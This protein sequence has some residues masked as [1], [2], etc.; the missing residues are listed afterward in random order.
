M[1]T[2]DMSMTRKI[3]RRMCILAGMAV[4]SVAAHAFTFDVKIAIDRAL[5]SPTLTVRYSGANVALV[6]LKV[7]GESVGTRS[8]T[9]S[10]ANGETN[11]TIDLSSLHDG[12][13]SV[14]ISLFDKNGKLVGS[15]KSNISTDD[16]ANSPVFLSAPKVGAT[17]Q[18]PVEIK[19]GFGR[20]LRNSYVSFFIDNQF[21]AMMNVAPFSYIWDSAKEANGWHELEAWVVDDSSKT[22]KTRKVKIFVNNPGGQ[23]KRPVESTPASNPTNPT[24]GSNSGIKPTKGPSADPVKT[25]SVTTPG[26]N[27]I[28][29]LNPDLNSTGAMSGTKPAIKSGSTASG[30]KNLTP[31]GT[32]MASVQTN[33]GSVAANSAVLSG[34]GK[35]AITKGR[36][37]PNMG[38]L[39]MLYNK[40]F[41]NFDVAPRVENGIP[42]TPIRHLLEKA[43]GEVNWRAFEKMVQAKAEG[44]EILIWIGNKDA[45]IDGQNVELEVAPFIDRGRTIVPISFIR[46][47]LKVNIEFD[48]ETGH[49][50][51]TSI[52]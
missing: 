27:A 45:K 16:S 1:G 28:L 18:G 35:V 43:G 31:T 19:V 52:K 48:K 46:E 24:L 30:P 39:V 47:T 5:N 32:R 10:K 22:M 33:G 15:E 14:E 20:E 17:V 25:T 37:L 38:S 3:L 49:V 42:L 40:E 7:N 26:A 51:I 12:D 6:E 23:T 41:V 36:R 8:V 13:N 21:K 50:L 44:R 29:A 4:L 11:F 2:V 9:D 34:V